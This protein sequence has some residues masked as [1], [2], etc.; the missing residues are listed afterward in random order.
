MLDTLNVW[1]GDGIHLSL[2][3]SGLLGEF[4]VRYNAL[5]WHEKEFVLRFSY[6]QLK[7]EKNRVEEALSGLNNGDDMIS[8]KKALVSPYEYLFRQIVKVPGGFKCLLDLRS[9]LKVFEKQSIHSFARM[10]LF[11]LSELMKSWFESGL[12]KSQ[13]LQLDSLSKDCVES[14]L[15]GDRVHPLYSVEELERR[16]VEGKR[17]YAMVHS[18]MP[19]LPLT[20]VYVHFD[21]KVPSSVEDLWS[22]SVKEREASI[23]V[24]Y[25]I[26]SLHDGLSGMDLGHSLIQQVIHQVIQEFPQISAVYTLSPIPGLKSWIQEELCREQPSTDFS[27]LFHRDERLLIRDWVNGSQKSLNDIKIPPIALRM[28]QYYLTQAKTKDRALNP[29]TK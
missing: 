20:V 18:H 19:D 22:T 23:L 21:R 11:D 27:T 13:R 15:K 6:R 3:R 8:L 29:V 12:M 26:S 14:L 9:D 2:V 7:I 24:L 10:L 5:E 17:C 1:S 28:T 16:F 25:S 4:V